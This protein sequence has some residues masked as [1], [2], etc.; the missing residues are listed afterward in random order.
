MGHLSKTVGL[1]A[2]AAMLAT[3]CDPETWS[4]SE[5]VTPLPPPTTTPLTTIMPTTTSPSGPATGVER[6]VE[7]APSTSG[8]ADD[9]TETVDG[10][11]LVALTAGSARGFELDGA[12]V[13]EP[14]DVRLEVST[15]LPIDRVEWRFDGEMFRD[16]DL[17]APYTMRYAAARFPIDRWVRSDQDLPGR[18][19]AA[20]GSTVE[21]TATAFVDGV[22]VEVRA[23]FGVGSGGASGSS[24]APTSPVPPVSTTVPVPSSS[25]PSVP[26][27]T[28]AVSVPSTTVPVSSVGSGGVPWVVPGGVGVAV[29]LPQGVLG[30]RTGVAVD[31]ASVSG[32]SFAGGVWT[33][34]RDWDEVRD[35][36]YLDF[37]AAALR[38]N[39]HSVRGFRIEVPAGVA[40]GHLIDGGGEVGWFEVSNP[41]RHEHNSF[42]RHSM[43]A[44]HYI[45][46]GVVGD[47]IKVG[48]GSAHHHDA[49]IEMDV[50]P[51]GAT[52]KH[53]DGVQV[54]NR[55]TL[56]LERVVIEW[57][58]AGV[59][60]NTTGAL[61][62]QESGALFSRDVLVLNPGGTWQPV[63]LSGSGDHDVDRIQVI[64]QRRSNNNSPAKLAPTAAV[65]VT[66]GSGTF[67]LWNGVAGAADWLIE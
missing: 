38:P 26:S 15:D 53:Y 36:G 32:V 66:N 25:V 5:D 45:A 56:R 61:F 28:V 29:A 11:R 24:A 60:A 41:S 16:D 50:R 14:F 21:V 39:G 59:I 31:P 67:T 10:L 65:K 49:Y 57:A 22:P 18:F 46:R 40:G 34:N 42:I 63:R 35:G 2:L 23:A 47:A 51:G 43:H 37:G 17:V 6:V 27:T 1:I 64:G 8:E 3:G 58:D 48:E 13:G 4:T 55:G 9:A 20:V 30:P 52:D 7:P 12:V 62:T 33:M 54:F 19:R 44:H